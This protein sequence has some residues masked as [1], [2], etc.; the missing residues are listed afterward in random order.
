[1]RHEQNRDF[2]RRDPNRSLLPPHLKTCQKRTGAYTVRHH[3]VIC[4]FLVA[5]TENLEVYFSWVEPLKPAIW[6]HFDTASDR[7][8]SCWIAGSTTLGWRWFRI[9]SY[10]TG[11]MILV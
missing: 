9:A 4:G 8:T 10:R 2:Q 7:H 6:N 5:E 1:M 11:V 3:F